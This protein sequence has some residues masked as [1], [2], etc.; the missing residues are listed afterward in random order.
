MARGDV[1]G[2]R[3]MM[4]KINATEA[5]VRVTDQAMRTFGGWGFST[6]FPVERFHRDSMGNVSAGL[7][8]DR[9]RDLLV[10]RDLDIDPWKYEPFNWLTEAGLAIPAAEPLRALGRGCPGAKSLRATSATGEIGV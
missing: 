6:D 2:E 10:F 1:A 9:L 7:T 8:P 4:A 3:A 5:A